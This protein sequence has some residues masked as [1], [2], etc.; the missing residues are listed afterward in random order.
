MPPERVTG[1][2]FARGA[3][4]SRLQHS[5]AA[6]HDRKKGH[7]PFFAPAFV[8]R[9]GGVGP[10]IAAVFYGSLGQVQ[11]NE[12]DPGLKVN[13]SGTTLYGDLRHLQARM[14]EQL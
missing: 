10:P 13:F 5:V 8:H 4:R 11:I 2:Q 1:R 14:L 3:V 9:F 7:Q 12:L 6:A